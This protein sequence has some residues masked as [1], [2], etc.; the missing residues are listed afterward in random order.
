MEKTNNLFNFKRKS[1][2]TLPMKKMIFLVFIAGIVFAGC[3]KDLTPS[4]PYKGEIQMN[5]KSY[6]FKDVNWVYDGELYNCF[7]SD[8]TLRLEVYILNKAIGVNSF[9]GENSVFFSVE[10]NNYN[11][12]PGKGNINVTQADNVISGT[13]SGRFMGTKDTTTIVASGSFIALQTTF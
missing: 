9:D 13:F 5:G 1:I 12:V 10:H 4:S 6:T 3:Q 8:T 11:S 7:Y 2:K